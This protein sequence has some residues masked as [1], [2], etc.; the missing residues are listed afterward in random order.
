MSNAWANLTMTYVAGTGDGK[1][2][3][4]RYEAN[5]PVQAY[6]GDLE[7]YITCDFNGYQ[8][9]H[10][11]YTQTGYPYLSE[12]LS[13]RT[14]RGGASEPGGREFYARLRPFVSKYGS[15]SVVTDQH[16]EPIEM[17][18]VGD[19]EWR[20]LVP[21][22]NQ[23]LTN[24]AWYF[25]GEDIYVPGSD[26]FDTNPVYWAEQAQIGTGNVPYGG[27][28]VETDRFSRIRVSASSSGYVQILFNTRT[29]EYMASRAEYQNFNEWPAPPN[30][31]S[32]S[33]GQDPK[34]RLENTFDAW[35]TNRSTF[36][37]EYFIGVPVYTNKYIREPFDTFNGWL[38]GSAAYVVERI[39]TDADNKPEGV[40]WFRN[41]ALRL[42]GGDPAL[43]LG[44]V[45]NKVGTRPDG[46]QQI[47]FDCRLGQAADR[48]DVAYY[49]LGFTNKNYL[50][51]ATVGSDAGAGFS[52]ENP[53][54]SVIGYYKDPDNFYE[55]R[56]TQ[57]SNASDL[58]ANG[59]RRIHH[60]LFKWVGGVTNLLR[61]ST[62]TGVLTTP[63]PAEMRLYNVGTGT[64]IHCKFG[65]TDNI[66]T[67]YTDNGAFGVSAIQSG[68]FGFLSED[69]RAGFHTVYTQGTTT[70]GVPVT[71]PAAALMLD[72]DSLGNFNAQIVNWYTP[73][74]RFEG[75]SDYTKRG[76]YAVI[77]T[78]KLGVYLQKSDR[79][80]T[81]APAAPGTEAWKL[82]KQVD[83]TGFGYSS[84]AVTID[85]WRSQFVMLQVMGRSD[86]L[87]IDVAVDELK[88]SSWRG[89]EI[90]D[91]SEDD[92]WVENEAENEEWV[93]SEA[94]VVTNS[95]AL[96]NV[97]QLDH[98]RGGRVVDAQ[99]NEG[100][101]ID[102]AIRS[103]LLTNG[104]GMLEFDYKVL[105]G[106]AKL[107]VQYADME[108]MEWQSIRSLVVTAA[109]PSFQHE[110]FYLG[111]NMPG[112]L[113][114]LNERSGVYTNAL[115]EFNNVIA[116]DEPYIE[117]TSWRAYNVK[118]TDTDRQRI[119]LDETKA[120]FLNNSKTVETDPAQ[121]LYDPFLM[122][123]LL[124]TG[125][126]KLSF[127]ARMYSNSQP[128][129]VSLYITTVGPTAPSNQWTKIHE[130]TVTNTLYETY[131]FE[132][133]DGRLY[134]ALKLVT[135]TVAGTRRV[136]LEEVVISEPV[137]PGFEIRNVRALCKDSDGEYSS[138][139]FQ[140]MHSD[141]VG[142]EA[143]LKNIQL[144]PQNIQMHVSYY[145]G[146]NVW[147]VENW[148]SNQVVTLPMVLY[149]PDTLIYRTET[150]Q[151]IPFQ[152]KDQVVQYYVWASYEDAEG[153]EL[154]TSQT[155]FDNPSWYYPVDLNQTFAA[156]GGWSPYYIVYGVPV[157]AV[158]INEINAADTATNSVRYV[159]ENQYIEIAVPAEVDL[160]GWQ[161]DLVLDHSGSFTTITIPAGLPQQEPV[162]NGYAFFVIGDDP[163]SRNSSVPPLP[164]MD[165]GFYH[166]SWYLP[167]VMAGGVRLRRPF[168]MYEQSVAYD[169]EPAWGGIYS[170]ELWAEEDPE[171]MFEYVGVENQGGSLSVVTN[172]VPYALPTVPDWVFPLE[173]TPGLPNIGQTIVDA[174]LLAPGVSNIVIVSTMNTA[175]GTQNGLRRTP[176]SLKIRRGTGTNILYVADSWY[177]LSSILLNEV[178]QLNSGEKTSYNLVLPD[179]QTNMDIAVA[180]DLR[181]D[182]AELGLSG[183]VLTWLMSFGDAPLAP[184]YYYGRELSLTEKYWINANPTTTNYLEG[185]ILKI[186][187][188]PVTTNYFMT[189]WLAL[190]GSNVTQLMGTA[191][192]GAAFKVRAKQSLT[193]PSWKM[194]EQYVFSTNSFDSNHTSRVFISNP[195][196]YGFPGGDPK[197]LFFSWVIEYED[198]RYSKPVLINS[199]APVFNP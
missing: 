100:V 28:C 162:T 118:V 127:M 79:D 126:G 173:W 172:S 3:S 9:R 65:T 34:L 180:V 192:N 43:G 171:G 184:T 81:A 159:G 104:M 181:Q 15:L 122:S 12:T 112:Y 189:A 80:S 167:K 142:I 191:Q 190:N 152:E 177:R 160:A 196:L 166:L 133:V 14:L 89:Q 21:L 72:A 149:D 183:E 31:F 59:D 16:A 119:M 165:Y 37:S 130:F 66:L 63:T 199:N 45:H 156:S 11:D 64:E 110:L 24:L 22:H 90:S 26:T 146:T 87:K 109:M 25:K 147:G 77:P 169:W 114:V 1:G 115:V 58:S 138:V 121:T 92:T 135:G 140:P 105:R 17:T 67:A 35:P 85:Q 75:R 76:I 137:F 120:G 78:Q 106:P 69:C 128:A 7:Y 73:A 40:T 44:Y 179:V 168:G 178:E 6:V 19:D 86:S 117:D 170:G 154:Q 193:D 39:S 38:A 52:P 197:Q 123:P 195:F 83:L 10:L 57:I 36:Y 13:P 111:T 91:L 185:G 175:Y 143:Q 68:S 46:I 95:A 155:V 97:V 139:R 70:G 144:S 56:M 116:W 5:L 141:E 71:S 182:V 30:V 134:R 88:V 157:G 48:F 125:L 55:Y 186:E 49:K 61:E 132:P 99:G 107:T 158:W 47:A 23:A 194:L 174:N 42:K 60:R 33:S 2:N 51:R 4:E 161:V 50:V 113:R 94:W 198:P 18:L 29:L 101:W 153:I 129:T 145:V 124:P 136:C 53:S 74:G 98:S 8:Y 164:K 188:E 150:T 20:G 187:Q 96:R 108:T 131:A 163:S 62:S 54:V 148:P 32:D 27:K 103:P 93:A 176:Y 41:V 151:D 84:Q 102:Q 82:F